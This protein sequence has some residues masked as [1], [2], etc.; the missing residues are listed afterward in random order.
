MADRSHPC[1]WSYMGIILRAEGEHQ[2]IFIISADRS[3]EA[4]RIGARKMS[5]TEQPTTEAEKLCMK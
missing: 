2:L 4:F 1:G 3:R 5:A